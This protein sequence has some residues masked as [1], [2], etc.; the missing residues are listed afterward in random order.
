ML[1]L[2]GIKGR[3]VGPYIVR[4]AFIDNFGRKLRWWT[5]VLLELTALVVAELAVQAVRRV[6]WP[7]DQDLMQRME[8]DTDIK[9]IFKENAQAA[10][11]GEMENDD[12]TDD[13]RG[14]RELAVPQTSHLKEHSRSPHTPRESMDRRQTRMSHDDYRTN[15]EPL[16]EE[17]DDPIDRHRRGV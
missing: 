11:H 14:R 15:F 16:E 17:R 4:D 6:Y 8:K 13:E 7:T 5:T 3:T 9:S 1:A 12:D 2:S 10:E